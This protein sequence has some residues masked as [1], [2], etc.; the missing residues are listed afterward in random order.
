M[1]WLRSMGTLGRGLLA[2]IAVATFA[3]AGCGDDAD[4]A[5]P[6]AGA[7]GAAAGRGNGGPAGEGGA[8]IGEAGR[9]NGGRGGAGATSG[10]AG[11]TGDSGDAGHSAGRGSA[12]RG[13]SS[14]A[15]ATFTV[16]EPPGAPVPGVRV[17][18]GATE[19]VSDDAGKVTF[20]GIAV[21]PR[22]VA[23]FESE[24]YGLGTRELTLVPGQELE[25]DVWLVRRGRPVF[26][27]AARGLARS[28]PGVRISI[29]P[30]G[31]VD[32]DG[33]A[34]TGE[35]SLRVAVVPGTL[36]ALRAAPGPLVAREGGEDVLLRTLGMLEVTLWRGAEPLNLAAGASA[37]LM[38]GIPV[39]RWDEAP[40]GE[41]VPHWSLDPET[42]RWVPEGNGTI[43]ADPSAPGER[44]W[45]A[46]TPHFS[47]HNPDFREPWEGCVKVR[48]VDDETG[49]P[50]PGAEVTLS[51]VTGSAGGVVDAAGTECVRAPVNATVSIRASAP[52]YHQPSLVSHTAGAQPMSCGGSG[53]PEVE[54]RLK[55]DH[56]VSGTV[57]TSDGFAVE[58]ATVTIRWTGQSLAG[59]A[60]GTTDAEGRY[61]VRVPRGATGKVRASKR[62]GRYRQYSELS[63]VVARNAEASCREGNCAVANLYLTDACLRGRVENEAGQSLEGATVLAQYSIDDV[64]EESTA[65]SAGDGSFCLP[66]PKGT[67]VQIRAEKVTNMTRRMSPWY[68]AQAADESQECGLTACENTPD[69]VVYD[70]TCIEGN[71]QDPSAFPVEGGTVV[72]T[73]DASYR[74]EEVTADTDENGDY[75]LEVPTRSTVTIRASR[76]A[77][78]LVQ[79]TGEVFAFAPTTGAEC[80]SDGCTAAPQLQFGSVQCVSGRVVDETGAPWPDADVRVVRELPGEARETVQL[81]TDGS[82]TY[83]TAAYPGSLAR[84]EAERLSAERRIRATTSVEIPTGAGAACGGNCAMAADL[85]LPRSSCLTGTISTTSGPVAGHVGI[86]NR[87]DVTP[88]RASESGDYCLDVPQGTALGLDA[89]WNDRHAV[90]SF[91]AQSGAEL[92]CGTGGCGAGPALSLGDPTCLSGVVHDANGAPLAGAEITAYYFDVGGQFQTGE[93]LAAV[94]GTTA[95]NG[96][97][98]LG[99]PAGIDLTLVAR[100]PLSPTL[101]ASVHVRSDT[102]SNACGGTCAGAP[103][104]DL[105]EVTS[106]VRGRALLRRSTGLSSPF[107]FGAPVHLLAWDRFVGPSCDD[108]SRDQP[109]EWGDVLAAGTVA[110]D[111]A[112]CLELDGLPRNSSSSPADQSR[113]HLQF[114]DCDVFGT[115]AES[116]CISTA[117]RATPP[118]VEPGACSASCVD[119][120]TVYV[121][122]VLGD[123]GG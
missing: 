22:L 35:I 81:T 87:R 26:F 82:G 80:G 108:I 101:G 30:N 91:P 106:C 4:P 62:I 115:V 33:N 63:T 20:D 44:F 100:D 94:T 42:A 122:G 67:A 15:R 78:D 93:S 21:E 120:G 61:C 53:C 29:P 123:C 23:R 121:E 2:V 103:D 34:V 16:L 60:T 107:P 92:S 1:D 114:G 49:A 75:C 24:D 97:Y 19:Q 17:T 52:G 43:V 36:E 76:E 50:I 13:G 68:D 98:C 95:G 74:F 66:V 9:S 56:C 99:V 12:G 71:V 6:R 38:L 83:C 18:L 84:V 47:W 77:D 64:P 8:A 31:V 59:V 109:S 65:E 10:E 116:G 79:S 111:G 7:G 57:Q 85:V 70:P 88:A 86:G 112:F 40:I 72:G 102:T 113:V 117:W 25:D 105:T 32:E 28:E 110:E 39:E 54:V 89:I 37:R 58:G 119:V 45:V 118:V 55:T 73:L 11:L 96:T 69:L 90:A 51:G 41:V 48:V 27:D 3:V 14:E 46:E 5:S 104:L